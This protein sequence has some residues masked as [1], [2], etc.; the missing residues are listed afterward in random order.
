[1]SARTDAAFDKAASHTTF[2]RDWYLDLLAYE[3][4][5]WN[6]DY[7]AGHRSLSYDDALQAARTGRH[8]HTKEHA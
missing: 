7:E 5:R 2:S 1:M 6:E 3:R 8:P 4:E